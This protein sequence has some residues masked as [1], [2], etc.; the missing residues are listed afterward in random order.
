MD[1]ASALN[2]MLGIPVRPRHFHPSSSRDPGDRG[3]EEMEI[4]DLFVPSQNV[5]IVSHLPPVVFNI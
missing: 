2:K 1:I 5:G 4:P 3:G